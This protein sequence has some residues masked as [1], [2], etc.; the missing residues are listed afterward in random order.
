[1]LSIAAQELLGET[2]VNQVKPVGVLKT[3]HDVFQLYVVVDVAQ[4]VELTN[5]FKL[6]TG[7]TEEDLPT[8]FQF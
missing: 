1:M 3:D 5:A 4:F 6:H 2:E 8:G 7:K